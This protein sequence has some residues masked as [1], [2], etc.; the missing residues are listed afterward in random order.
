MN[1]DVPRAIPISDGDW[2]LRL[3]TALLLL[4]CVRVTALATNATDLF[5]DEAQYWSWSLEPAFG[6]YSKPPLIAWLIRIATELFGTSEFSV[7]LAS[8]VLHTLTALAVFATARRLFDA[9]TGFW[10]GTAYATLPGVSFSSGIISTD[11]PLLTAWAFALYGVVR[12]LDSR[13]WWPALLL[14]LAIGVGLNAKYAMA[15]LLSG[16]LAYALW[17][18]QGRWLITDARLYVALVV[19]LLLIAPNLVWNASN[20]FATFAHTADNAKWQGQLFHPLKALEFFGAQFGVFGPVLFGGLIVIVWRGIRHGFAEHDKLL[21]SFALPVIAIVTCQAFI[22]RAH[23]NWAAVAYVSATILVIA[24]IIRDA[25]WGWLKTSFALHVGVL[26]LL[27]GATTNA[28]H[29]VLPNGTAPFGRTIGWQQVAAAT[30]RVVTDARNRQRPYAAIIGEERALVAELMFYL[31]DA[32][33]HTG[34]D[35]AAPDIRAW[36]GK[37][38]ATDHYEMSRPY[39]SGSGEPALLVSLVGKPEDITRHFGSVEPIG[40]HEIPLGGSAVRR[41]TFFRVSGFRR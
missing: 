7:R 10:A 39:G 3:A 17:S 15:Y 38:R 26:A 37:G 12:L 1:S 30:A 33:R 41:V 32:L 35:S 6:Y 31:P 4:L 13:K 16:L 21:L 27:V 18:R 29:I 20:S 5:F 25:D 2:L 19:G 24:T 22:S 36:S 40:A 23:A 9:R 11:V 34:N 28:N 14:G 8:P